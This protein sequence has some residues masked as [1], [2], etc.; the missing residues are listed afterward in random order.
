MFGFT[1]TTEMKKAL[2]LKKNNKLKELY[3]HYT[4]Y[5]QFDKLRNDLVESGLVKVWTGYGK[6][7]IIATAHSFDDIKKELADY[8]RKK[9]GISTKDIA[10][11]QRDEL[12]KMLK[13]I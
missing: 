12:T 9:Q 3:D 1:S 11:R 4:T 5:R 13:R 8:I 7:T 10:K 6:R 2:G